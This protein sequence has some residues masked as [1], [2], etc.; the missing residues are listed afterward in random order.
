MPP[1]NSNTPRVR[2]FEQDVAESMQ[3][4]QASVLHVALAE[5]ERAKEVFVETKKGAVMYFYTYSR[6]SLLLEL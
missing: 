6:F 4:T 1:L 2:T 5:Q 3:N